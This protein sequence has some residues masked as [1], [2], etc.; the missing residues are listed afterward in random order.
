M[1]RLTLVRVSVSWC[2]SPSS[3]RR[4]AAGE[5]PLRPRRPSAPAPA[6][7]APEPLR[8]L[9]RRKPPNKQGPK[10]PRTR[11]SRQLRSTTPQRLLLRQPAAGSTK[12]PRILAELVKAGKLPPW[13]SACP[14]ARWSLKPV[15][16]VGKYGGTWRTALKGGQDDAWLTRTVG[17]DY[18][19]RWDRQSGVESSQRR[20]VL[21]RAIA[22][23]TEF[24][25]KL[26][27]GMKWSDGDPFRPTTSCSGPGRSS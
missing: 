11:C 7:K 1:N 17:Y 2:C 26:R 20:R 19:V 25:F 4:A 23:A 9:S 13:T 16:E 12:K 15:E 24:T 21:H 14:P 10:A 5:N 8:L 27:K 6:A 18:L 3:S 22:D